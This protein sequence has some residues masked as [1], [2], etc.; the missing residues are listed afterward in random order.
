MIRTIMLGR[1]G[2]NLF[3]YALGRVLA[4]KHGVPLV[5]DGSWFNA[6]GWRQVSCIRR[7]PIRARVV[8]PL[9]LASRALRKA[10]GKHHWECIGKPVYHEPA[11]DQSYNPSVLEM[12][13]DCVL[14]G[15]FQSPLFFRGI[16][17][18]LREELDTDALVWPDAVRDDAKLLRGERTV[19]V[20][21][22]RTDFTWLPNFGVCDAAYY[23]R[24]ME[25]MRERVPGAK[26]YIFSDDPSW[27]REHFTA[28]DQ[29]I[30]CHAGAECDPLIDFHLMKQ[31][32]HHIIA[33]SSYSWW[34]AWL[35]K[36]PGQIVL[37][38]PKWFTGG[39]IAPIK[40]KLCEGWRAL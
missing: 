38:P 15:Y 36:K 31:A 9:S 5:M 19:A 12:P 22:R 17:P 7:L 16:E 37:C 23:E 25:A 6:E 21:V 35:G 11:D 32:S 24:A 14:M 28:M 40:E 3:Q 4:E 26:F 20:H 34:A 27:C 29:T 13:G 1:F 39:I 30:I 10:T 8:R 33:N 2:N 18:L